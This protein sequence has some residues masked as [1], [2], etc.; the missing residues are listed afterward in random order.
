MSQYT[1]ERYRELLK[2]EEELERAEEA[3]VTRIE[4]KLS[5]MWTKSATGTGRGRHS[6]FAKLRL[7]CRRIAAEITILLFRCAA[8]R[9]YK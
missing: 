6:R 5:E 1:N 8:V 4:Q 7:S 9:T 2:R 3:H